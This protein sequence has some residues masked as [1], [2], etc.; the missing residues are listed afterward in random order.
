MNNRLRELAVR[1]GFALCVIALS[2]AASGAGGI[3]TDGTVGAH[4]NWLGRPHSL[5]GADV[6]ITQEMGSTS[7][8][9]L[10]HSF[11]EFNVNQGQT[12]TFTGD[13][14]LKNVISRVTGGSASDIAGT[15]RSTVG[16][17]DVYLINPSGVTFAAGARVDV[18]AAFRVSTADELRLKDGSRYSAKDPGASTLSAAAPA[19]FGYL[20]TSPANNGL[21]Q[22]N[23]AHLEVRPGQA[24]D[25]AGGEIRVEHGATLRAEAGEVRLTASRGAGEVRLERDESGHLPVPGEGLSDHNA[26]P[27]TIQNSSVS[28]SGD[29]GGRVGISG[30]QIAIAGSRA[31]SEVAANNLGR[32]DAPEGGGVRLQAA[33]LRLDDSRVT[34]DALGRGRAG[35]V[36]ATATGNLQIL[37]GSELSSGTSGTGRAGAVTARAGLDVRVIG[38]G[39]SG[40]RPWIR[41]QAGA[42]STGDAG[43][44]VV[45]ADR[46]VVVQNSGL[47]SART[48]DKGNS[49]S[50][51]VSAGRDVR[52]DGMSNTEFVTGISSAAGPDSTGDA[53]VVTV[54]AMRDVWV[55]NGGQI[56]SSTLGEGNAGTVTVEAG[57]DLTVDGQGF[58]FP[59]LI[60][61]QAAGVPESLGR[62]GGVTVAAGRDIA[63]LNGGQIDS[64][65]F[66]GG[67][68]GTVTV[69]AGRHLLVDG[70][71]GTE[72]ATGIGSQAEPGSAGNAGAVKVSAKQQVSVVRG[73]VISSSTG[74]SGAGGDVRVNG[75][76]IVVD[77]GGIVAESFGA[78]SSG[79]TGNID[80]KAGKQLRVKHGGVISI[81][82]EAALAGRTVLVPGHLSVRA[83]QVYVTG[84]TINADTSGNVQAGAIQIHAPV[85]LALAR[86]GTVS[87]STRGTAN[88]G[89]VDIDTGRLHVSHSSISA[90]AETESGGLIGGIGISAR[91][92]FDLN[93]KA[94]IS[95][96][97]LA[98]PEATIF[99]QPGT[100]EIDTPRMSLRN[101]RI[102]THSAGTTDAGKIRLS[103]TSMLNLDN[104]SIT[105]SANFGNG[106]NIDVRGGSTAHLDSSQI[107]S[108]VTGKGGD[109]G[110]ITLAAGNL[111]MQ[112]GLI[113]AN[114]TSGNGGDVRLDVLALTPSGSQVN[115]RDVMSGD[116]LDIAR[117]AGAWQPGVFGDNI[118]RAVSR[119]GLSGNISVSA[120]QLNLAGA[121][122]NLGNPSYDTAE[123]S[124]DACL[125][126]P[127]SSLSVVGRG[128]LPQ[129]LRDWMLY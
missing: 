26:G 16:H 53:G 35:A 38:P 81:A 32:H 11:S 17:A 117:W 36:E 123:V 27:V 46:D 20:G 113:E 57:Q 91:E 109:G 103:F 61:S 85:V 51:T 94:Q 48:F 93:D 105:T 71:N 22:V 126:E 55:G 97:N 114:A 13:G 122:A 68:A 125:S 4:G 78:E 104:S 121:I 88:A 84:G 47:I 115:G 65:T 45:T 15:L 39:K 107:R 72:F 66:S 79:Q 18:P 74:G 110:D 120:P 64:T 42:G 43:R 82:N 106:G 87:S 89:L 95:I 44:V 3:R 50:V 111:I 76:R 6:T 67:A 69:A 30:G 28:T 12:V 108:S 75:R 49:G 92:S 101:S 60:S 1:G 33:S 128:G 100:I 129:R 19:A 23:G 59:A 10:F 102:T 2:D 9:N 83:P 80:V 37:N 70:S 63:V 118:I 29:G 14:A 54:A 62:G 56:D 116:Y 58:E 24:L 112:T 86:N 124:S 99:A 96:E 77:G 7:G 98:T 8:R 31:G 119:T 21:I 40:S 34:A 127:G 52:V 5:N 73:G 25:V 41:S 90:R